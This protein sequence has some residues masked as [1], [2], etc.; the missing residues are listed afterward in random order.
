MRDGI[1]AALSVDSNIWPA[2]DAARG[3]A[4]NF[5]SYQVNTW[6]NLE[7]LDQRIK[8]GAEVD[9]VTI[10]ITLEGSSFEH[11]DAKKYICD[12]AS[13]IQQ[14]LHEMFPWTPL[15]PASIDESWQFFGFDVCDSYFTSGLPNCG[16]DPEL[17][18]IA[19]LRRE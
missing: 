9:G 11:L 3:P 1:E 19:A 16:Y 8:N 13:Q 12:P 10:A 7:E 6:S 5:I 18:D 15:E 17:E 2:L 4:M 14:Y